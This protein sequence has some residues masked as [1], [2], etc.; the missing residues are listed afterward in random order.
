MIRFIRVSYDKVENILRQVVN[1]RTMHIFHPAGAFL[2]YMS[3]YQMLCFQHLT[4]L[5]CYWFF[6]YWKLK[7]LSSDIWLLVCLIFTE[8]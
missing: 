1:N 4:S 6:F 5:A 2:S 7:E 3:N 8:N